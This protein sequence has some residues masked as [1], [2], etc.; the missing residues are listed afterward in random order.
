VTR[1]IVA[2]FVLL[3]ANHSHA[4]ITPY[5][6]ARVG[7]GGVRHS[8]LDFYPRFSSFSAGAFIFENIGIEGFVD[9]SLASDRTDIFDVE[10]KRAVGAAI[11]FQ[12]PPQKG[13]QAYILLGYVNFGMEQKV[14][15]GVQQRLNV[16][17][18]LIFGVEYRNDYSDSGITVD[19][20]SLG[21]RYELP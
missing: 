4:A 19:G 10:V 18:G 8:E 15:V 6:E 9:R 12:S 20:L 5:V 21:L 11:R 13:L 2:L 16:V 3:V 1:L 14:S 17:E 7:A